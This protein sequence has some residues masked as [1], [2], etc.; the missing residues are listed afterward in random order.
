[1]KRLLIATLSTATLWAMTAP[2][3]ALTNRFEGA[4]QDTINRL[5][6]RFDSAREGRISKLTDRFSDAYKGTL[7][8]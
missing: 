8:R 2:A 3:F 7:D 1:M 6:D 4:R 5:T